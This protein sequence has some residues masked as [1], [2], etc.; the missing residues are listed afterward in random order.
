MKDHKKVALFGA[1]GSIGV[2]TLDIIDRIDGFEVSA[3]CAGSNWQLL[4]Q[5]ALH[6]KP[7]V[8]T[9]SDELGYREL[10]NV[11][12]GTGIDIEI[13]EDA[14]SHVSEVVDYDICLN[15]LVGLSGLMPSYHALNR[16][17]R[18]ALAN[19]ESLVL[20]GDILNKVASEC[21]G[22]IVPVDS[23]HCAIHQCLK[24]ES[25]S[26]V[27]RLILTASGGPFREWSLERIRNASRDEALNHPT[28]KMGPKITIDSATLM[29][30]GLEVIEAYHL[31]GLTADRISVC[32]H[33]QSIVHSFVEYVDGNI[34]AQLGKPDMRLPIQYALTYPERICTSLPEDTPSSWSPLTFDEVDWEKFPCLKLAFTALEKGGDSTAALN[35]ADEAAVARFLNGDISFGD[36]SVLIGKALTAHQARIPDSIQAVIEADGWG[37]EFVNA[38]NL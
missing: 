10:K 31:F 5:Q 33:P 26:E 4:A 7:Q 17:K 11:L 3:L 14:A 6:Y 25:P 18:L 24:G 16:G 30:K 9:L 13:G 32:I 38:V 37:R 36:I 20:A 12:T 22:E 2:Q 29:N 19:K 1:T 34:K 8:I 28:W 35:G 23:E 21:D 27:K 15:G